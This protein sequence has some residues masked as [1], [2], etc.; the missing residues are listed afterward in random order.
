MKPEVHFHKK[1]GLWSQGEASARAAPLLPEIILDEDMNTPPRIVAIDPT[2]RRKSLLIDLN[3]QFGYLAFAKVQSVDW[4]DT[5]GNE[6]KGGLYWPLN[7]V[8]GRKYPLVIQTHWWYADKFLIDGLFTTAFAAQALAGKGFFVLQDQGPDWTVFDT[9]DEGS[10]AMADYEGAIDYLDHRGLIDRGRVGIIGFSRT[11]YHVTYTLTHSNYK[12]AAATIADGIDGGYFQHMAFSNAIPDLAI[13][14]DALNGAPPF[15]G[16]LSTWMKQSPPF[17]MEKVQ[18]PLLVQA[19]NGPVSVG[20]VG[21]VRGFI[22]TQE[23]CG[24]DLHSAWYA[25]P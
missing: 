4:K 11:C 12:F 2:S 21:V 23:T 14:F 5:L 3:P 25:H 13:E 24:N 17:L 16:G 7:Y 19:N 6:A 18:A 20:T 1:L 8:A 9:I 22:A 15:G 10:R